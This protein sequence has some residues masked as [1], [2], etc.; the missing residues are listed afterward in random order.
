METQNAEAFNNPR[1]RS[2]WEAPD[3][4]DNDVFLYKAARNFGLPTDA[5]EAELGNMWYNRHLPEAY[6][7]RQTLSLTH[8][9]HMDN[10]Y[11]AP[12]DPAE[13]N[14]PPPASVVSAYKQHLLTNP[15]AATMPRKQPAFPPTDTDSVRARE[16]LVADKIRDVCVMTL[17]T[18]RGKGSTDVQLRFARMG[19]KGN[20]KG[21]KKGN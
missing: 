4:W 21:G 14:V 12:W 20:N 3:K 5:F 17:E 7:M 9:D 11:G 15:E 10:I 1:L 19:G 16:L 18:L 6:A 8:K 13:A 2:A